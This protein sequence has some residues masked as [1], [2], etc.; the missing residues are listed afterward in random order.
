VAA[1]VA[2]PPQEEQV[3]HYN[4]PRHGVQG[5]FSLA[6]LATFRDTLL[7][8]GRWASLRVWRAGQAEAEGVLASSVVPPP[9][10]PA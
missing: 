9:P 5:P 4:T 1:A 8:L 3:W 2:L 7:R 10:P 6:Q